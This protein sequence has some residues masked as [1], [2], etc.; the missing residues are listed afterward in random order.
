MNIDSARCKHESLD[1][2][3]A[4]LS[5]IKLRDYMYPGV[6]I[7]PFFF[8]LSMV[9]HSLASTHPFLFLGVPDQLY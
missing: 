6:I 7:A 2:T 8:F 1:Q 3:V 4:D 5:M 9:H